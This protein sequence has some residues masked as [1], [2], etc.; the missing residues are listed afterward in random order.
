MIGFFY[1]RGENNYLTWG[2]LDSKIRTC[3]A[4]FGLVGVECPVGTAM[5]GSMKTCLVVI[6]LC[7]LNGAVA[8]GQATAQ[9]HGV[10]QDSS[11]AAVPGAEVKATQT[12][13]G[14]VRTVNSEADGSY[15]LTNLPLGRY[16]LDVG[17]T[18]FSTAVQE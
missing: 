4:V 8:W 12:D 14:T 7:S 13:T 3:P 6:I 1:H 9:I 16:R 10:V 18:G 17:K 15:V 5:G 11:G 2:A